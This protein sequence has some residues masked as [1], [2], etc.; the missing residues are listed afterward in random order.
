M[1]QIVKSILKKQGIEYICAFKIDKSVWIYIKD[2]EVHF[3]KSDLTPINKEAIGL[4]NELI[5]LTETDGCIHKID[6]NESFSNFIVIDSAN[7]ILLHKEETHTLSKTQSFVFQKA[8]NKNFLIIGK[9]EWD[10]CCKK[11]PSHFCV[12]YNWMDT[13]RNSFVFI[14]NEYKP[15]YNLCYYTNNTFFVESSHEEYRQF[16]IALQKGKGI[17]FQ[18]RLD[19]LWIHKNGKTE[20]ISFEQLSYT[21]VLKNDNEEK[22][23]Y[24]L[25][26]QVNIK[27]LDSGMDYSYKVSDFINHSVIEH[28]NTELMAYDDKRIFSD[29]YLVVPFIYGYGAFIIQYVDEKL[30]AH[31]I[32]FIESYEINR[33]R[34]YR[35]VLTN[36]IIKITVTYD[37]CSDIDNYYY[38]ISGNYLGHT[39][40]K[41]KNYLTFSNSK[42]VKSPY[43]AKEL[44]GIIKEDNQNIEVLVPPIYNNVEII[45]YELG[46]FKVWIRNYTNGDINIWLYS[47]KSGL[48]EYGGYLSTPQYS[49]FFG[50]Y[51]EPCDYYSNYNYPIAS[52]A[53]SNTFQIY[54][55]GEYT[56]YYGLLYLGEK[57]LDACYDEIK[58][59]DFVDDFGEQSDKSIIEQ[60]K[61][62]KPLSVI[63]CKSDLFGIF[64]KTDKGAAKEF[65][66][67]APTFDYIRCE[68]IF[69]GHAYF[70][71]RKDGKYGI[72]SDNFT[73]N[74]KVE[75]KYDDALFKAIVGDN[76]Y[77]T[78][79]KSG[80]V[81]AVCTQEGNNIPLVFD[82]IDEI[83]KSG[84]ISHNVLYNRNGEK[85]FSLDNYCY[86]KTKFCDVFQ[87]TESEEE[88]VFINSH[89]KIVE[90]Q[91]D[92]DDE[93]ILH[94]DGI[95]EFYNIEDEDFVEEENYYDGYD[96]EDDYNYERDTYYALGGDDYE[97]WKEN[98]GDLDK[99]MEGMGF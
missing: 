80:K 7:K 34:S 48:I 75:V 26:S 72:I 13:V 91:K 47:E 87:S 99:M 25:T 73:F 57:V 28:N 36:E 93:N 85:I 39:F 3:C 4:G 84:V 77:F 55:K 66:F 96:Y 35:I 53:K 50:D 11:I 79:E 67:I 8:D 92:E 37:G 15:N 10:N 81:G 42:G 56:S 68:K 98:G 51:E 69:K 5:I 19:Y 18:G 58:G 46:L 59:F 88:F 90:Y 78:V 21:L 54:W 60:T 63:V 40:G 86:I 45:D 23:E 44:L 41:G 49:N 17:V 9:E 14:E 76:C 95:N 2:G 61:Q 65:D 74:Q 70:R 20:I 97:Q 16:V 52:C 33:Y 6:D 43:D 64:Y 29:N 12:R 62:Y 1:E 38:D 89:G 32:P 30:S 71:V 22:T 24:Y 82:E 83:A 27:R 94:V 31:T